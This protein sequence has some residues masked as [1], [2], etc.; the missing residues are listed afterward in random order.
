VG[1]C[2]EDVNNFYLFASHEQWEKITEEL[3]A[4]VKVKNTVFHTR[5]LGFL[6][7]RM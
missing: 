1:N 7:Y 6:E 5:S 2:Q 3:T 4:Q